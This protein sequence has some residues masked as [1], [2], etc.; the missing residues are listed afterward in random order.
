MNIIS[1]DLPWKPDKRG[2]RA[3]AVANLDGN[4]K[5]MLAN[6]DNEMLKLV[7]DNTDPKSLVLLDIPIDGCETLGSEHSRPVDK[8]LRHQRISIL[9]AS[10]AGNRGKKLEELLIESMAKRECGVYEIYPYAIYKFLACLKEKKLLPSLKANKFDT[11]LNVGF[12]ACWPPK[13]KREKKKDKR[14]ENMEYLY[15]L[16]MDA[17]IG[18]NFQVPLHLPDTCRTLSERNGLCDEYDACLGAIVGIYFA[19]HSSYACLVGKAETGQVLML[20]DQW[21]SNKLS[22]WVSVY[23][24]GK[25]V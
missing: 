23:K 21:L 12:R 22:Q 25:G 6:D 2:P 15:S 19:N 10:G 20:A 11:L 17:S 1:I 9:P 13:Y 7:R 16:L 24:H 14:L 18:L 8:A 5:V 3:L 4:I